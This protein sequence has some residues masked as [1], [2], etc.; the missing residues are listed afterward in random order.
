M[1]LTL[2]VAFMALFIGVQGQDIYDFDGLRS[3]GELTSDFLQTT[4]EKFNSQ[5]DTLTIRKSSK[6][7]KVTVDFLEQSNFMLDELMYSGDVLVNDE[8]GVYVNEV[9]DIILADDPDL[10]SKLRAY[11]TLAP[12]V[13]AFANDRG[14][15]LVNLG[16]FN[17]LNNE[18][19]LASILAHEITHFAK[20]HNLSSRLKAVEIATGQGSKRMRTIQGF[21]LRKHAYDR[22]LEYEADREGALRLTKT[23]Y[24]L[25]SATDVFELLSKA[26][27]PFVNEFKNYNTLNVSG[28]DFSKDLYSY[29]KDMDSLRLEKVKELKKSEENNEEREL[30]STHPAVAQRELE[31]IETLEGY[32]L[33]TG[34]LFI[35]GEERFKRCQQIARLTQSRLLT[36]QG[37]FSEALYHSLALENELP[38]HKYN[39]Q[40]K[41]TALFHTLAE[42][43]V[44]SSDYVLE[45]VEI[46]SSDDGPSDDNYY[47]LKYESLPIKQ[48]KRFLLGY[49]N[50]ELALITY[51]VADSCAKK[52]PDDLLYPKI[53]E[54]TISQMIDHQ[55]LT[56]DGKIIKATTPANW[57]SDQ[58][59]DL[60]ESLKKDEN[61]IQELKTII[62]EKEDQTRSTK[63][64]PFVNQALSY[65]PTP[66]DVVHGAK[67]N[68][69][70]MVII[71]PFYYTSKWE[72]KGVKKRF[73]DSESKETS[74]LNYI[75]EA[76]MEEGMNV[77]IL[78]LKHKTP[79]NE[80]LNQLMLMGAVMDRLDLKTLNYPLTADYTKVMQQM[81]E[82]GSTNLSIYGM[83]YSERKYVFNPRSMYWLLTP[84][85]FS[86][87]GLGMLGRKAQSLDVVQVVYDLEMGELIWF[88]YRSY[89][90]LKETDALIEQD[91]KYSIHQMNDE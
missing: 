19:E 89:G 65:L 49:R 74:M 29:F 12:E 34:E 78:D 82:M 23:N 47:L 41:V 68:I 51:S 63:H 1:K 28:I 17:K 30:Y 91:I 69:K 71:S 13:N 18:A 75:E 5:V 35:L 84:V 9:L 90:K 39:T 25:R 86:I 33:D 21:L 67:G 36:N 24:K 48:F 56:E 64:Y 26:Q 11:I 8:V 7:G 52:Y 59:E 45:K 79:S 70:D 76:A 22:N 14:V 44:S 15:V 42:R 10:R 88:A 38:E 27:E 58:L 46:G 80:E 62:A 83:V 85:P 81:G 32:D 61:F 20:Q 73:L 31:I 40:A 43:N 6:E 54:L 2:A 53:K 4:L 87:A 50:F 16:L 55:D 66:P 57:K 3:E 37:Q 60:W 72:K 77:K